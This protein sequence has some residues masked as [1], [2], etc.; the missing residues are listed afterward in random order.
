[1][2][3]VNGVPGVLHGDQ[4]APNG[5]RLLTFAISPTALSG[6]DEAS[7]AVAASEPTPIRVLRVELSLRPTE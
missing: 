6:R 2:L 5:N 7:L 4:A 1:M 3:S